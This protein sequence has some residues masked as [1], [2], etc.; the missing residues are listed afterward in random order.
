MSLTKEVVAGPGAWCEGIWGVWEYKACQEHQRTKF[1]EILS[2]LPT[3][4]GLQSQLPPKTQL[5]F[6]WQR[7][8]TVFQK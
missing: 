5:G 1:A 8:I 3:I 4:R 7:A 2:I 6:V